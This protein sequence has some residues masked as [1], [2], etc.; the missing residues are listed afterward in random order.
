MWSSINPQNNMDLNQGIL[1]LLSKFGGPSSNGWWVIA[2]KSSKWV[3]LY[4]EVKFDLE[5]QGQS[6]SKTIGILTKV[7]YIY[8][9]N[10]VILAWVMSYRADKQVLT[11]HTD[12]RT[13]TQTD[14]R[15]QRQ[16]PKAKT[17]LR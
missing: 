13:D 5:G 9:P 12:G 7:F 10:L 15:R 6:P 8:G 14:R 1:H 4:F 11:A 17:G 16:Y 3:N 2:R